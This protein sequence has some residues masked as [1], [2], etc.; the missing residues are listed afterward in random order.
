MS[1][2]P[3]GP[4]LSLPTGEEVVLHY[5]VG[6]LFIR[7]AAVCGSKDKTVFDNPWVVTCLDCLKAGCFDLHPRDT[8]GRFKKTARAK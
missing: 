4:P 3:L 8:N 6:G 7:G 5:G 1:S 2:I